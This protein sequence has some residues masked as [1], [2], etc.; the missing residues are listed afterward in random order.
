MTD[1]RFR[2]PD[3][4]GDEHPFAAHNVVEEVTSLHPLRAP[5]ASRSFYWERERES[6]RNGGP[7][8][9][10]TRSMVVAHDITCTMRRFDGLKVPDN[11]PSVARVAFLE[12][13]TDVSRNH[14]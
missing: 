11:H 1:G 6:R 2:F 5:V 7:T 8:W 14:S 9:L 4:R 12:K 3:W 10:L 13:P